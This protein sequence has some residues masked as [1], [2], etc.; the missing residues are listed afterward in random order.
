MNRTYDIIDSQ[1]LE[2]ILQKALK[3][4]HVMLYI[5]SKESFEQLTTSQLSSILFEILKSKIKLPNNILVPHKNDL[6]GWRDA[7]RSLLKL[8]SSDY[9]SPQF[10]SHISIDKMDTTR[11][12]ATILEQSGIILSED[13]IQTWLLSYVT[14]LDTESE[15]KFI[16][17]LRNIQS[18]NQLDQDEMHRIADQWKKKMIPDSFQN[19]QE[20]SDIL[21]HIETIGAID[22]KALD[23]LDSFVQKIEPVSV[24]ILLKESILRIFQDTARSAQ[25]GITSEKN[26]VDYGH[27]NLLPFNDIAKP[28]ISMELETK[29]RRINLLIVG[30]TME[31]KKMKNIDNETISVRNLKQQCVDFP[32]DN[33]QDIYSSNY[34]EHRTPLCFIHQQSDLS[35]VEQ[36]QDE[37]QRNIQRSV[38]IS[39]AAPMTHQ[40]DI[41]DINNDQMNQDILPSS[42]LEPSRNELPIEY[43][44]LLNILEHPIG[45]QQNQMNQDI[46][47]SSKLEPGR[48]ELPRKD[49]NGDI[50]ARIPPVISPQNQMNQDILPSSKLEP[51]RDEYNQ[52]LNILEHKQ[53]TPY[54]SKIISQGEI[55]SQPR[56]MNRSEIEIQSPPIIKRDPEIVIPPEK[57]PS[58]LIRQTVK[59]SEAEKDGA[60]SSRTRIKLKSNE[61]KIPTKSNDDL[62]EAE[63]DPEVIFLPEKKPSQLIRQIVKESKAEKA[64]V[65]DLF[66]VNPGISSRTRSKTQIPIA[67]PET[68]S[69]LTVAE[70]KLQ[71]LKNEANAYINH[72][73]SKKRFKGG[74]TFLQQAKEFLNKPMDDRT[75]RY[76]TSHLRIFSLRFSDDP[77]K[78]YCMDIESM[79]AYIILYTRE[80]I[81]SKS[82]ELVFPTL[83]ETLVKQAEA[84]GLKDNSVEE[85]GFIIT[86]F[87]DQSEGIDLNS[88]KAS[89]EFLDFVE[90]S[91]EDGL[92]IP[93]PGLSLPGGEDHIENAILTKLDIHR[94]HMWRR[95]FWCLEN[96]EVSP[97]ELHILQFID[98]YM[99]SVDMKAEKSTTWSGFTYLEHSARK[100]IDNT[101]LGKSIYEFMDYMKNSAFSLL[102]HYIMAFIL[103]LIICFILLLL[104]VKLLDIQNISSIDFFQRIIEK[105]AQD[106]CVKFYEFLKFI[107]YR[108]TVTFISTI[109]ETAIAAVTK[110]LI[111]LNISSGVTGSILRTFTSITQIFFISGNMTMI[112]RL[113]PF[114]TCGFSIFAAASTLASASGVFATGVAITTLLATAYKGIQ[115]TIL[116][117]QVDNILDKLGLDIK[118]SDYFVKNGDIQLMNIL[119][120]KITLQNFCENRK[121][122][123]KKSKS[124]NI[125]GNIFSYV[126]SSTQATLCRILYPI[127]NLLIN[128]PMLGDFIIQFIFA[129][130]IFIQSPKS[131]GYKTPMLELMTNFCCPTGKGLQIEKT[132]EPT[133]DAKETI[134]P[135]QDAKETKLTPGW[136]RYFEQQKSRKSEKDQIKPTSDLIRS[137]ETKILKERGVVDLSDAVKS[138][139]DWK[140]NDEIKNQLAAIQESGDAMKATS[141]LIRSNETKIR[142]DKILKERGVVDLSDAVK[143]RADWKRNDEIKNQLRR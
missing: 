96:I 68:K 75:G 134:E 106:A 14:V 84:K 42:K 7:I 78:S 102:I 38:E 93:H 79:M 41:T 71:K 92:I 99:E 135:T 44:E 115:N 48:D 70:K 126:S 100:L 112:K 62:S 110:L 43:K 118:L 47:P 80:Y 59:E 1:E 5:Q 95:S 89:G 16:Q 46:L 123:A 127:L 101:G 32:L 9:I 52:L 69:N 103:R 90:S 67:V 2:I 137:N 34:Q 55:E 91:I 65:E 139:A 63:G 58:Q 72:I 85:W 73:D 113:V 97:E 6:Q 29:L 37:L 125:I 83:F 120:A 20:M 136:R 87:R 54:K 141:D 12:I 109:S 129:L 21:K 35:F 3:T 10:T 130:S 133:S 4:S 45:S 77:K 27:D 40:I 56:N 121:Q 140:R 76:C 39:N 105:A 116:Y 98:G 19:I 22:Q 60:I 25:I 88:N 111:M 23:F 8:T 49:K 53:S 13:Q 57:K 50:I 61:S 138:R 117:F 142:F 33:P 30:L 15:Q 81:L 122:I 128:N 74:E 18:Q 108:Q 107:F 86:N 28:L 24:A 82:K 119:S 11:N 36:K 26:L 31:Q 64:F 66:D 131:S 132:I 94:F 51:G 124:S 143:S 17:E 104:A 114:L